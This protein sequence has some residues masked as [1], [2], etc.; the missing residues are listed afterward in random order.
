M[1]K[2]IFKAVL[3]AAIS[4][5]AACNSNDSAITTSDS[6]DAVRLGG[7]TTSVL[8]PGHGDTSNATVTPPTTNDNNA[9]M[10]NDSTTVTQ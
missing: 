9:I 2:T 3:I 7:D 8:N 10:P 6:S 5:A 1:K 4:S